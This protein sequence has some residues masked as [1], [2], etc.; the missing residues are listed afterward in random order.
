MLQRLFLQIKK[1]INK[2]QQPIN[3]TDVNRPQKERSKE[4]T[5]YILEAFNK[6]TLYAGCS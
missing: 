3:F 5:A 4:F 2:Y 6:G 1:P